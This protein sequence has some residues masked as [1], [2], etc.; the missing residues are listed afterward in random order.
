MGQRNLRPV[1]RHDRHGHVSDERIFRIAIVDDSPIIRAVVGHLLRD[2]PDS[3]VAS[4][5]TARE[6]LR[7]IADTK[8]D[9][10]IA[11]YHLSGMDGLALTRRALEIDDKTKVLVIT[12]DRDP[13]VERSFI[14]AG[15]SMVLHK[16]LDVEL[17]RRACRVLA[18]LPGDS[19]RHDD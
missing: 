8:C 11:D 1:E 12:V 17:L 15:A 5:E 10:L 14:E 18:D 2:Q 4:F 3:E 6:C 16:P 7:W 9:L 13:T 19:T